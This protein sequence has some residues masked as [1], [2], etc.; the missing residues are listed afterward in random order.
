MLHKQ[1]N[2]IQ[3]KDWK[4]MQA[5]FDWNKKTFAKVLDAM[6]KET[7]FDFKKMYMED[8]SL[9]VTYV[10]LFNEQAPKYDV[11]VFWNLY[12]TAYQD[13]KNTGFFA[14]NMEDL[15]LQLVK[16]FENKVNGQCLLS[17]KDLEDTMT[18]KSKKKV[19]SVHFDYHDV[20]DLIEKAYEI[21]F[22]GF[23]N[24]L[25]YDNVQQYFKQY[26]P[27]ADY[28][29]VSNTS[30]VD[31][32]EANYLTIISDHISGQFEYI[33]FWHEICD[34]DFSDVSN[35]SINSMYLEEVEENNQEVNIK[36]II[37]T[38]KEMQKYIFQKI[39]QVFF[40]ELGQLKEVGEEE[41]IEFYIVW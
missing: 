6:E 5:Y 2:E 33:D 24:K 35:G 34:A 17:V 14:V 31:C 13:L 41:D 27:K 23:F 10:S 32:L 1:M 7:Q 18:V 30:P 25:K 15:K 22:R 4:K 8:P 29:K 39:K 28:K 16:E 36:S 12:F 38:K 11:N 3:S 40:K 37:N 26:C 9:F 20:E 19:Q 21:E